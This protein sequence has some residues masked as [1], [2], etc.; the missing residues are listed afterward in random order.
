MAELYTGRVYTQ[1]RKIYL[2][3]PF[4]IFLE[5]EVSR[6]QDI[7][8]IRVQGFP[9]DPDYITL[10]T[11]EQE[12]VRRT[13][14]RPDGET[15]DI[16][17][18]KARARCHKPVSRQFQPILICD[19]VE[20]R[21]RGFFSYSS[22]AQ[23]RLQLTPLI[24]N[25]QELPA[26]GRPPN[27]SGAVGR[28]QLKGALSKSDVRPGDLVTLSLELS[29]EGWLNNAVAPTP[30]ASELFKS[31]P[32]RE[33]ARSDSLIKYEQIV[34]PQS[35]NAVTIPPAEFSFFNPEAERYESCSSPRF[36]L[37]F[38]TAV[39]VTNTN[40]LLVIDTG[41]ESEPFGAGSVTI[42]ARQV[43]RAFHTILP[44]ALACLTLLASSFIFLSLRRR[45]RR[46]AV[47]AA[48]LTLA[49]GGA[50]TF[51]SAASREQSELALKQA[52]SV[53]LAP[54]V[55][56]PVIAKLRADAR[57]IPLESTERWT[58][59]RADESSGWVKNGVLV[60]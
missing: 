2:N 53:Y 20:R 1:P 43:N 19:V 46:A 58:R 7:D 40:D 49:A 30:P 54:S 28:F 3:Q 23:K 24:L 17:L 31:Y 44:V 4:E 32:P 27:F 60:R 48:L 33:T 34:I 59:I 6:G 47:I 21:S 8:N 35:T 45:N 9:S 16:L 57:V 36:K 22:S 26:Q 41:T 39:A 38:I 25:V 18:F 14:R 56:S 10:G 42:S 55:K 11:L 5:L 29:G 12:K 52:A 37:N 51:R 13:R 50:L 15:A